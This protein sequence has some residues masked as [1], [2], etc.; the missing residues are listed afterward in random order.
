MLSDFIRNFACLLRAGNIGAPV[1]DYFEK[2]EQV[3]SC[4]AWHYCRPSDFATA[5]IGRQYRKHRQ[6]QRHPAAGRSKTG[7]QA[8]AAFRRQHKSGQDSLAGIFFG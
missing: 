7:L 8:G 2:Y 3:F 5:G 6:T 4:I 1:T